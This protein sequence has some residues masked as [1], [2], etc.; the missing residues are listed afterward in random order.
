MIIVSE[1]QIHHFIEFGYCVV[2]DVL[3]TGF[4]DDTIIDFEAYLKEQ[5]GFDNQDMV[6]SAPL[7]SA[8]S[9]TDGAGGILDIFWA[10]FKLRVAEHPNIAAVISQLWDATFNLRGG[11]VRD[12]REEAA[13]SVGLEGGSASEVAPR[14]V[15]VR[16][17][18]NHDYGPFDSTRPLMAVDRVC[19]RLPDRLSPCNHRADNHDNDDGSNN[20]KN[21]NN[22][23]N[24]KKKKDRPIQRHLAPHLDCCPHPTHY[25][26]PIQN[27][28]WRPIQA[29]V[30]LSDTLEPEQ[31]GFECC[32]KLHK[33]FKEWA[34]SRAWSRFK[35]RGKKRDEGEVEE[36]EETP[37][38]CL[39]NFTPLR[40]VEDA[41]LLNE[42]VHVPC[43]AGSMVLW[44]N[45]I[46]HANS[47][48]HMGSE[49]RK[50][51]YISC[52]PSVAC[53]VEYIAEQRKRYN[54]G[55][56]PVDFW[57][58]QKEAAIQRCEYDFSDLGR[59]MFLG[60]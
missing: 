6:A 20:N 58:N 21:E 36:K 45:R 26:S 30:S 53:N 12:A 27:Q 10:D 34:E 46:P 5:C 37:P 9:S 59:A 4:I 24:K 38:P 25:P 42:M 19:Y 54:E 1:A 7:L 22:N 41:D 28:K 13:I 60:D 47:R 31:G 32:P 14:T 50:V 40:P 33:R 55:H 57:H 8:L 29:F 43:K 15:D 18:F 2:D 49:P 16:R 23:N 48:R 17:V 35:R 56:L 39:G 3:D 11:D 51:I 44:D 52:L